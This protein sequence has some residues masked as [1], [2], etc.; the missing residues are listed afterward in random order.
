[1]NC[2]TTQAC[3]ISKVLCQSRNGRTE[4]TH[5]PQPPQARVTFS[6]LQSYTPGPFVTPS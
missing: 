4:R 2:L 5:P 3:H 6:E 1:M